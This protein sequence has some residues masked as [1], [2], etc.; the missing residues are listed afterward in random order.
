M[1]KIKVCGI[2][3]LS[4]L[5]ELVM[6]DID[7]AGLIFYAGSPRYVLPKLRT[8]DV[9][10]LKGAIQKVG[11][12][13]NASENDIMTQIELYE[14]DVVQLHGNETPTFCNHISN[15][16]KVIKAFRINE[17]NVNVDWLIMPYEEACDFYL[18]DQGSV[19]IY[20]G[21]GK[22]F[23]WSLIQKATIGKDFFL[24]G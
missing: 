12:F 19:G 15:H 2:T 23:N 1:M 8:K 14:L 21:T 3:L 5:E 16:V 18:F 22:K 24:S 20:G 17:Q 11:V 6:M 10:S 4:Q 7:Y 9:A 13:V